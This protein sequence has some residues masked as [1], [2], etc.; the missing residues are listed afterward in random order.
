MREMT[1][2]S[3]GQ[4]SRTGLPVGLLIIKKRVMKTAIDPFGN[5]F[6]RRAILHVFRCRPHFRC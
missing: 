2:P 4:G 6:D 1:R 5:S 3:F